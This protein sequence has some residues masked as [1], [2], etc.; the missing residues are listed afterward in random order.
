MANVLSFRVLAFGSTVIACLSLCC[1]L[2][3]SAEESS[4]SASS[5]A[6][7]PFQCRTE[8][9]YEWKRPKEETPQ[10]VFVSVESSIG[11]DE[12]EAKAK[13]EEK[14]GASKGAAQ[15]RCEQE[16]ENL[17]G[18]IAAKFSGTAALLNNTDFSTRKKLQEAIAQDCQQSQGICSGV[19][20]SEL[21]CTVVTVSAKSSQASSEGSSAATKEEP[22][23]GA[24]K[25]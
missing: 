23:K 11:V 18:C 12:A 5:V 25:K 22:K 19:K 14:L 20:T 13:L 1:G 16:R 2:A 4:S 15:R 21:V 8:L 6:A 17:S 9:T 10:G 7:G 24:K 3:V